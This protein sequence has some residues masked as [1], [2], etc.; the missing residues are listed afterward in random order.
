MQ[1]KPNSHLYEER[2]AAIL[3]AAIEVF[4]KLGYHK[5]TTADISAK[6]GISQPYVYRFF[7]SKEALFLEVV[8][9]IY[10][11]I[12]VEF[13]KAEYKNDTLLTDLIT[14][15]EELMRRYPNEILL[16]IQTWGIAEENVQ[17]LVKKSLENLKELVQQK[18]DAAGLGDTENLAKDFLARGILC[19][20]AFALGSSELSLSN[21][22]RV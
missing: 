10:D 22:G 14:S 13:S 8:E 6:A 20:L 16:Q 19:N 7:E 2:R 12:A 15:Y 21:G 5:V 11:R 18:F 3:E 17:Q 1:T 4:A 9:L